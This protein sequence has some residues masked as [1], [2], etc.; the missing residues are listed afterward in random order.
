MT[1]VPCLSQNEELLFSPR[2]IWALE[3][4]PETRV[5]KWQENKLG[6]DRIRVNLLLIYSSTEI[7]LITV[8]KIT[9]LLFHN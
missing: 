7:K 5:Q 1:E 2:T 8:E 3:C 6:Q 9:V 4:M